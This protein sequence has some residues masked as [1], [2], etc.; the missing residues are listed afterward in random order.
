MAEDIPYVSSISLN[1]PELHIDDSELEDYV[2]YEFE[3]CLNHWSKLLTDFGMRLPP[4]HLMA[5]L[6]NRLLKD[7]VLPKLND[8]QRYIFNLI[9][10]AC[11]NNQQQLVFVYGHG[12]TGKTFLW[13]A[14]LYTLPSEGKIVLAV[15]SS[16][17]AS[18]TLRDILDEP[19]RVFGG[20]TVMLGGDF[21]QTLPVKKGVTR[22]EIIQSS[23]A[24]SYLWPH[25]KIEYLT[26]NMRLKNEG[27]S[28]T[29]KR[30]ML[31]FAQ[32]LVDIGNGQIGTPDE[33]DLQNTSWIEIPEQYCI[34][35]D[36]NAITD[37]INFIYD[38]D[39][40]QYPSAAKLQD[41]AIICPKNDMADIINAKILSLLM[42]TTRTYMSYD[43]AIPHGHD[44]GEV[45]L[46]YPKEYL[47]TLTFAGLP[48]HKLELKVGAPI[49]LLRNLNIA[50]GLC[51]GT[52]LIVTQLLPKVIEARII[53][54]TRICQKVFLPRIPLTTRDTGLPFIFKRKQFPVKV[55]YAMTI[56][57]AQGQSLNKIG[58]YLSEPV[59]RHGQLYVA[60]SRA[61]TPDGLKVIIKPHPE[62]PPTATK[63]IVYKDFLSQLGTQQD[64]GNQTALP[65]TPKSALST[66]SR[67][68]PDVDE[69]TANYLQEPQPTPL[70]IQ[71]A[72]ESRQ[73]NEPCDKPPLFTQEVP[74]NMTEST[75]QHSQ[76]L[77]STPSPIPN[78]SETQKETDP[79]NPQRPS[80][81][82]R[83]F[84][85]D[86]ATESSK[87]AKKPKHD[88]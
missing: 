87:I 67:N 19:N 16:G 10:T 14:I 24:K 12:G 84:T 60:L 57:K 62:K 29:D 81:R 25:F 1:I 26:E 70:P 85:S 68:E 54:G 73:Q 53:T 18:L 61:T 6:R 28:E 50:G 43:D 80:A 31:D 79:S 71:K 27:L 45:E 7:Q 52:R 34:P 47:N 63:N 76:E 58:V 5:V 30:K 23:I 17:I 13:K 78:P 2:L 88:Y 86:P 22:N 39:T 82:K 4:E 37:L 69:D 59:F 38:A 83:L 77:Q 20:K 49:M 40:L 35:H 72:T 74:A 56:N 8:K 15:A 48:P 36:D 51:N 3:A 33:N 66:T 75:P 46:L 11:L 9:V 44:G 55:C 32:W 65:E 64:N 21:R 41:K 42:M